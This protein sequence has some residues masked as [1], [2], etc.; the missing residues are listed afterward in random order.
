MSEKLNE[1]PEHATNVKCN[2]TRPAE[3]HLVMHLS[4]NKE[5]SIL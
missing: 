3:L 2:R 1:M 5:K 4:I